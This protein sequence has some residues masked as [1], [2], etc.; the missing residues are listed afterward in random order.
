M[1]RTYRDPLL[2][3]PCLNTE[4]GTVPDFGLKNGQPIAPFHNL[5]SIT[6]HISLTGFFKIVKVILFSK[7][8]KPPR[9]YFNF[10]G[11]LFVAHGYMTSC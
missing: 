9:L 10:K 3:H 1:W 6:Y 11:F 8:D 4:P 7:I 5:K 2:G